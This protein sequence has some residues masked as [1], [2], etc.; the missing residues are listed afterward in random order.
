M[1]ARRR[2]PPKKMARKK[3]IPAFQSAFPLGPALNAGRRPVEAPL[4]GL[5]R[6]QRHRIISDYESFLEGW[7]A[8]LGSESALPFPKELIK[9][10]I[11]EEVMDSSDTE[12]NQLEIAYVRLEIFVPDEEYWTVTEFKNASRIA[13][14]MAG[15]GDPADLVASVRLLKEA[16]GE[17]AVKIQERV[18]ERMRKSMEQIRAAGVPEMPAGVLL[19]ACRAK[20]DSPY[21]I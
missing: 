9:K 8:P 21:G 18:S 17:S 4:F 15:T 13:E 19:E 2:R 5:N 7:N 14:E 1:F 6:E 16:R 10:S 12:R 3:G 11:F 20:N